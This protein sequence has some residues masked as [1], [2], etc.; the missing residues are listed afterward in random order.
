MKRLIGIAL[1]LVV[2]GGLGLALLARHV[3]TGPNVRAAIE[4]QVSAALGQPVTI[5]GLGASV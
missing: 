1:A 4:A 5:G 3:F 2:L